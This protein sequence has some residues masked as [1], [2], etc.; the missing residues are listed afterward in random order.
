[1]HGTQGHLKL[2]TFLTLVRF[3]LVVLFFIGAIANTFKPS[4]TLFWAALIVLIISAVTDLFDGMLARKYG[5]VT[6]F[7]AHADPLMDKFFYLAT[8]PLLVFVALRNEHV[9]H[10]VVLLVMTMLFLT[11][12]QW[13]TFLR[14]IGSMYDMSGSAQWAGKLRTAIN[15]PLIIAIYIY[16]EC[17]LFGLPMGFIA[18][19]EAIALLVNMISVYTY[20][21]HYWPSLKRSASLHAPDNTDE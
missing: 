17:P 20:T 5:V 7:G 14:A 13:V 19:F 21:R 10:A 8:M 6:T 2:V 16:E 18:A 9:T 11:R 3:P 1:M 12:D 15:F 4:D